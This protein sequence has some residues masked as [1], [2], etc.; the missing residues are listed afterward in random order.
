[1]SRG[2]YTGLSRTKGGAARQTVRS[3]GDQMSL[4]GVQR[5]VLFGFRN[6]T[7]GPVVF[8]CGIKTSQQTPRP[9]AISEY[10]IYQ[11]RGDA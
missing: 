4:C 11:N 5:M 9:G 6:N 7:A 2:Y 1:M 3:R 8:D 10:T